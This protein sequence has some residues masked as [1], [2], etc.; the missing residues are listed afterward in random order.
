VY[1]ANSEHQ[2]THGEILGLGVCLFVCLFKKT[3]QQQNKIEKKKK[4]V[5]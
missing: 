3:K 4:P 1:I 5:S 2:C